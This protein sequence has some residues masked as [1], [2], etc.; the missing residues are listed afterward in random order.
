MLSTLPKY[1][2]FL[3]FRG[4][5]TRRNFISFLHK[6]LVRRSI[7]TFK[8]DNDLK[9]GRTIS[10]ELLRAIAESKFGIV[11]IS[12]NFAASS[13]CLKELVEIMEAVDNGSLTVMPVFYGVH[14]SHLRR[15][16]G[17]IAEQFKKHEARE[18]SE[19]VFLWREALNKLSNISGD[20]SSEW[21]DDSKLV[22]GIC[23]RISKKRMITTR[24]ISNGFS[25]VGID[26][27]MQSIHR[28]MASNSNNK[29]VRV[30]GIW[31]RGDN[32]RSALAKSAYHDLQHNF[33]KHCYLENVKNITHDRHMLHLR[34]EFQLNLQGE[35]S[36]SKSRLKDQKVLL[37]ANEIDTLEQ[38]DTLAEDFNNF[39]PGSIVI[40]TTQN[41]QLF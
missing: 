24:T 9:I 28:L 1:D 36:S 8:D 31:A 37:V 14:P 13:W 41:K 10:A 6:E 26:A 19:E 12:K 34:E 7:R 20:C 16:S 30:I 40:I 32:G 39:G 25:L 21:E 27:H 2:V 5:D 15:N 38:L 4:P 11:V 23:D 17:E 18:D 3:S 29:S 22:D 35:H 33:E